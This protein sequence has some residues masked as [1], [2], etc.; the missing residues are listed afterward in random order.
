VLE[1]DVTF[2]LGDGPGVRA[3][4]GSFVHIPGGVVHGFRVDSESARY[5][6]LTT[7]RHGDFYRAITAP[8]APGGGRPQDPVDGAQIKRAG[9]EFGSEFVGPLPEA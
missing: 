9:Q 2:F 3:P 6:I 7:A 5:L 1:G 8:S 4:A